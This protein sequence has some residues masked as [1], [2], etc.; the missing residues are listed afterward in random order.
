MYTTKVLNKNL[1][2]SYLTIGD[3]YRDPHLIEGTHAHWSS[4]SDP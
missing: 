3:P 2:Q 4:W 1:V